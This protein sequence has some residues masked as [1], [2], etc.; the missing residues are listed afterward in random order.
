MPLSRADPT[1]A[2]SPFAGPDDRWSILYA[3]RVLPAL[4]G[5][6]PPVAVIVPKALVILLAASG[7]M[8]LPVLFRRA[9]P[10]N[11]GSRS[12]GPRWLAW[13]MVIGGRDPALLALMMMGAAWALLACL[14]GPNPWGALGL[15]AR[16]GG[17]GL[18]GLL[19]LAVIDR[20]DPPRRRRLGD[21]LVIGAAIGVGAAY[22]VWLYFYLPAARQ[23]VALPYV[24][25]HELNRGAAVFAVLLWP[26]LFVLWQRGRRVPAVLLLLAAAHLMAR[27]DSAS[28]KTA[29]AG[30]LL[31]FGL[32]FALP[33]ALP[34]LLAGV[35]ATGALMLPWAF[36]LVLAP[37]QL[38]QAFPQLAP[39]AQHRLY[40]WQFA[41]EHVGGHP[42]LGWGFDASRDMPGG[43]L[44]PPIGVEVM[45]LHPHN[46][47]LQ[48][49]L[50]LGLIGAAIM[51]GVIGRGL[52]LAA[53]H[54]ERAMAGIH[55]AMLAGYLVVG[56]FGYGVWQ[57]W[58][59]AAGWLAWA[60]GRTVLASD[61]DGKS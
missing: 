36:S 15:W 54:G 21:A 12:L 13:L 7:L 27:L 8:A 4:I 46:S 29:A 38:I 31:A 6:V 55:A 52:A 32:V 48:V 47:L 20:L 16:L 17:L 35:A 49:R 51:A 2:P 28:A 24:Y 14:W 23:L 1:A 45:P 59:I 22:L 34:L 60:I 18:C 53:R 56:L 39:S 37:D 40:I 25:L 33:R 42:W 58:W 19:L 5:L 9:G 50:E 11:L 26:A 44:R 61:R 41:V 43:K 3:D 30:A 57:N 10:R